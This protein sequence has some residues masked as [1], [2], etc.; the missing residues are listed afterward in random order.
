MGVKWEKQVENGL[1]LLKYA[2]FQVKSSQNPIKLSAPKKTGWGSIY[3][4]ELYMITPGV[5]L[6]K[7]ISHQAF[8]IIMKILRLCER[9]FEGVDNIRIPN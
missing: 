1:F 9:D 5:C 2:H 6:A 8:N 3:L 7:T 4:Y